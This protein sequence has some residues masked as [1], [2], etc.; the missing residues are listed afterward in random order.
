VIMK[1]Y[2]ISQKIT[3]IVKTLC[4]GFEC[5]VVDEEATVE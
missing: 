3:N 5:A 2:G 1:Q 4:N